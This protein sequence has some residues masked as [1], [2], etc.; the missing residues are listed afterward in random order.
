MAD[1]QPKE[2]R[3]GIR[4]ILPVTQWR[5]W[6]LRKMGFSGFKDEPEPGFELTDINVYD[7]IKR[8]INFGTIADL[9]DLMVNT[10]LKWDGIPKEE[11]PDKKADP[12]S[13]AGKM[14]QMIDYYAN[15]FN[16]KEKFSVQV[17]VDTHEFVR[18]NQGIGYFTDKEEIEREGGYLNTGTGFKDIAD[19]PWIKLSDQSNPR[20]QPLEYRYIL[21]KEQVFRHGNLTYQAAFFGERGINQYIELLSRDISN[22]IDDY[23]NR[24][25]AGKTGEQQEN[26]NKN[27]EIIRERYKAAIKAV[28]EKT[29]AFE[30]KIHY[31]LV[32]G[33]GTV[34]N[35]FPLMDDLKKQIM[36]LRLPPDQVHYTHTYKII[37]MHKEII[38]NGVVRRFADFHPNFR[39]GKEFAAGLDENGMPL[40]IGDGKIG[41][42]NVVLEENK[43]VIDIFHNWDVA[44]GLT[45]EPAVQVREVDP[46]F[47]TECH[48]VD[49]AVYVYAHYDSYRDD[50]RDA[51]YHEDSMSIMEYLME[52]LD[53]LE[54]RNV[55]DYVLTP[56]GTILS[57]DF[58]RSRENPHAKVR[59]KLNKLGAGQFRPN[60][61]P[62]VVHETIKSTHLNPAFDLKN[63]TGKA[64]HWGRKY[65]YEGQDQS[66]QSK[67]PTLTTRGAALYMLHRVIDQTKY[68]GGSGNKE[69]VL[70]L[71]S[72]IADQTHGYDI[73]PNLGRWGRPLTK[74]PFK[75]QQSG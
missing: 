20:G 23:G 48:P 57:P 47:I 30:S 67:E 36:G 51:R 38:V 18:H 11:R 33:R 46:R 42:R 28:E 58:S 9:N 37:D 24:I 62:D 61:D 70:Q 21:P 3:K 69:G 27:L 72:K 8:E 25:R 17:G 41:F 43:V 31:S 64:I 45:N 39:R 50:M 59:V 16:D 12:N 63:A 10:E 14:D 52:N 5:K 7:E 53:P 1:E 44:H 40:E 49:I 54:P 6:I 75:P 13:A 68:W 34:A 35:M 71:L 4:H 60:T 22:I 29:R 56:D 73:G 26:I 15:N 65:Y 32:S 2:Q 66:V 19:R 55:R 74:D